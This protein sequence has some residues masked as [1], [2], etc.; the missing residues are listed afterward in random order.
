MK[1]TVFSVLCVFLAFA[2]ILPPVQAQQKKRRTSPARGVIQRQQL[3]PKEYIATVLPISGSITGG[4]YTNEYL[5]LRLRIPDGW[6]VVDADTSQQLNQKGGE[7]MAGD[8]KELKSLMEESQT[9]I[10]QLFTLIKQLPPESP[11]GAPTGAM[12]IAVATP[13]PAELFK[14]GEAYIE[15]AKYLLERT[16]VKPEFDGPV[17]KEMLGGIEFA[18]QHLHI[19]HLGAVIKQKL[20]ATILKG[21]AVVLTRVYLN[22]LGEQSHD[23]VIRAMKFK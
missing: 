4:V 23:E 2:A 16:A 3:P 6:S 15:V 13:V 18:T 10:I 20:S 12:V 9:R 1:K 17:T 11:G 8:S 7:L 22:D 21:H 19:N 5:G 14:S